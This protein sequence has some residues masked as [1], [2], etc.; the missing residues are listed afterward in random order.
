MSCPFRGGFFYK[1]LAIKALFLI[2]DNSKNQKAD[3]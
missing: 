1:Y 3:L 2:K